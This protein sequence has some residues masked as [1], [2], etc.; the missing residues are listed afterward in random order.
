MRRR[1]LGVNRR[2][3]ATSS[4][5]DRASM[6]SSS[7]FSVQD[8]VRDAVEEQVDREHDDDEV[9][10]PADDGQVVRD[11]VP[12]EDQVAERPGEQRL[13]PGRHPVVADELAEQP[14]VDGRAA[15]ERQERGRAQQPADADP[16]SRRTCSCRTVT[17]ALPRPS[18]HP[19]P[20][21]RPAARCRRRGG[22]MVAPGP[23]DPRRRPSITAVR[24]RGSSAD[25]V[26]SGVGEREPGPEHVAVGR[27]DRVLG[28]LLAGLGHRERAAEL[29]RVAQAGRR[30][31]PTGR[32]VHGPPPAWRRSRTRPCPRRRTS[33]RRPRAS[34]RRSPR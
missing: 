3:R 19:V 23:F 11:E 31:A 34:R 8:V 21:V 14:A 25:P 26:G 24:R 30:T 15:R 16:P 33:R 5:N 13:A 22:R 28:R 20:H 6:P 10:Q 2:I 18:S 12:A 29:A 4:W 1:E 17:A 27:V 7:S 32:P 9:V